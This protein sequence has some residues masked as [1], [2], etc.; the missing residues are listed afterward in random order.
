ME[1]R[2][3]VDAT[4]GG[5]IYEN[6]YVKVDGVWKIKSLHQYTTFIADYDKGWS[7]GPRPSPGVSATLPPDRRP[8]VVDQSFPIFFVQPFHYPNPVTGLPPVP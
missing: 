8:S 5:A 1:G 6:E 3:G 7:Q 2:Y 4:V